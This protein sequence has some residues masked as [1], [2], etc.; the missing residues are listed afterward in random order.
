AATSLTA[1]GAPPTRGPIVING[2]IRSSGRP[3]GSIDHR[4]TTGSF[5][6]SR[7]R[8]P[9]VVDAFL[10]AARGA[11]DPCGRGS[12]GPVAG[13]SGGATPSKVPVNVR[14]WFDDGLVGRV[15]GAEGRLPLT[16]RR[17]E[18]GKSVRDRARRRTCGAIPGG[19]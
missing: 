9:E 19:V 18:G 8:R 3:R 10:A 6:R 15:V 13:R 12:P 5:R 2:N 16:V 14:H 1:R 4:Q 17:V 11:A 7:K